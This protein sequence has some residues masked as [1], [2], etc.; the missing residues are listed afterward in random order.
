MSDEKKSI[1]IVDDEESIREIFRRILEVN[2]Y[3]VETAETGLQAVEKFKEK[4]Y[5]LSLLDIRLPDMEGTELLNKLHK[6]SPKTM[7]IMVTGYPTL[8]NAMKSLNIGADA[9]VVKPVDP[10]ELVKTINVKLQEQEAAEAMGQEKI[11]EW[12][13]T[14]LQKLEK[15]I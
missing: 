10:S 4:Y 11:D 7:K 14:R 9:Y 12:I 3:N 8:E 13:T 15:K 2:G 6:Q 5:N 1:L